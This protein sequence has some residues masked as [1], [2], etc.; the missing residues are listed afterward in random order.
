VSRPTSVPPP[1]FPKTLYRAKVT[2]AGKVDV[3]QRIV[4][5]EANEQLAKD[6]GWL[7]NPVAAELAGWNAP[8]SHQKFPK[9][10]YRGTTTAGRVTL[11][12]RIVADAVEA[13]RAT[14]EGWF[15]NK[16]GAMQAGKTAAQDL[17][18]PSPPPAEPI[19]SPTEPT[20]IPLPPAPPADVIKDCRTRWSAEAKFAITVQN[21]S[22]ATEYGRRHFDRWR[23]GNVSSKADDEI[24]WTLA[25]PWAV[26]KDRVLK[27]K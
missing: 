11:D 12:E 7:T 18:P 17:A 21:V 23:A 1:D 19:G 6:E 13:Q 14:T 4:A 2:A 9:M 5:T 15:T 25:Q 24:R 10:L 16:A 26:V 27:V 20:P 8:R 22:D 3:E